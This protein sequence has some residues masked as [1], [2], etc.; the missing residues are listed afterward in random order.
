MPWREI[1]VSPDMSVTCP[2][3]LSNL[4]ID[5]I[6]RLEMFATKGFCMGCNTDILVISKPCGERRVRVLCL[7]A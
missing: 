7:V 6:L 5:N 4:G 2:N 1:G 3:C